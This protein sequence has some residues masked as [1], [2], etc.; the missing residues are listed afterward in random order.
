[1]TNEVKNRLVEFIVTNLNALSYDV[2]D[3]DPEQADNLEKLA[4]LFSRGA[5]TP[6]DWLEALAILDR[7]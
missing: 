5:A 7:C 4:D 2:E 1:M 3:S 6:Q